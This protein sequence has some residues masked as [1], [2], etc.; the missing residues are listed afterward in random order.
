M[1]CDIHMQV[2]RRVNG[3]W[4]RVE[5]LPPRPCS[6]CDG[7]GH[8]EGRPSDKCYWCGERS[9]RETGEATPGIDTSPFHDRNYTVFSVLADVRNDG[10]VTPICQP[11]GLPDDRH[12]LLRKDEDCPEEGEQDY[13]YGD[14]S[15]SWLTLAELRAYDWKQIVR[16]EGFL[17]AESFAAWDKAGGIPKSWCSSVGGGSVEHV[18]NSRMREYIADGMKDHPLIESIAGKRSYYTLCQWSAPLSEYCK[19]FIAFM[20]T[21]GG[22]G[23]PKDVRIIFGFDS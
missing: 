13:D 21:L 12:V 3:K 7:R 2:E 23:A 10:Y 18:T 6:C 5:K 11:R 19:R 22:L 15:H 8:Y 9:Q 1:G 16:D 14:H 17:D 20:E 4:Q